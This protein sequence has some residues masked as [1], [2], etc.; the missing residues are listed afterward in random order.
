MSME[1][2]VIFERTATNWAA[3]RSGSAGRR[4]G[5][6]Q[7]PGGGEAEH[8]GGD[9]RPSGE[10]AP[11]RRSDSRGIEHGWRGRDHLR[12]L[13]ESREDPLNAS[14]ALHMVAESVDLSA[15]PGGL[16]TLAGKWRLTPLRPEVLAPRLRR[17]GGRITRGMLPLMVPDQEIELSRG[18]FRELGAQVGRGIF[19]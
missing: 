11:I 2:A 15:G 18:H 8:P 16:R 13:I 17:L 19:E 12:D 10:L 9:R 5:H 3:L 1:C 7:D 6:R 14:E 4:G